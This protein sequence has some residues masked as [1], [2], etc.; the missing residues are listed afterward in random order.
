MLSEGNVI[1]R[2]L[3]NSWIELLLVLLPTLYGDFF[4][5]DV[6]LS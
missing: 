5:A 3:N 4:S 1:I 2:C 6:Q